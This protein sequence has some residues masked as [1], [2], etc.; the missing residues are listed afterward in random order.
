MKKVTLLLLV[1]CLGL[2]SACYDK[3]PNENK[4]PK[5]EEPIIYQL[6]FHQIDQSTITVDLELDAKIM[7]PEPLEKE[8]HSFVG[9]YIS[10]RY[11]QPF[12]K[13]SQSLL[14]SKSNIDV[15]P[16]YIQNYAF[17]PVSEGNTYTMPTG[18]YGQ[19]TIDGGYEL[20]MSEV[21]AGL[22][23]EVYEYAK[24]N[25]YDFQKGKAGS[26]VFGSNDKV[27]LYEPV[28]E[29]NLI[30]A[31]LFSNAY[32]EMMGLV[33]VYYDESFN[34]LKKVDDYVNTLKGL[35][36]DDQGGFRL[37]TSNEWEFAARRVPAEQTYTI[38][39]AGN[40]YIPSDFLSG[41]SMSSSDFSEHHLIAWIYGG[42]YPDQPKTMNVGLKQANHMGFFDMSGNVREWT[43]TTTSYSDSFMTVTRGGSYTTLR[44]DAVT[45]ISFSLDSI[46]RME[47]LGFRLART[48]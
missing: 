27:R 21:T 18:S 20:G 39:V 10:N 8:G 47:D 4:D 16:R 26:Y 2:L 19:A 9:W 32:S 14:T 1:L 31:I 40:Y 11:Q 44:K 30:D 23:F 24:A 36:I 12:D 34:V 25:G 45:G 7:V 42:A 35:I 37:P 17:K 43:I 38:N 33:P 22:Y 46:T 41:A 3:T 15:Y 5:D 13:D 48:N 29:V 28:V 6:N